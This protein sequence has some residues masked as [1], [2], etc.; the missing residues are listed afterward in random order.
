MIHWNRFGAL[1]WTLAWLP[2]V[3]FTAAFTMMDDCAAPIERCIRT[4]R[5]MGWT[6]IAIGLLV[7][8]AVNWLILRRRK[9]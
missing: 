2:V 7:L 8:I 3:Y 9:N 6:V 5:L 4:Q 1:V